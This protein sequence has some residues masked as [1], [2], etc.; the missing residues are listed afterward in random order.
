MAEVNYFWLDCS[1]LAGGPLNLK[2]KLDIDRRFRPLRSFSSYS[3]HAGL[4]C[5]V[6]TDYAS[7]MLCERLSN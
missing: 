1:D 4:I 3:S 6:V 2:C 7:D 5:G